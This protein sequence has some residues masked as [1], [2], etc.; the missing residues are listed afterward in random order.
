MAL[1]SSANN[2]CP[3][4]HVHGRSPI[5]TSIVFFFVFCF[6]FFFSMYSTVF[7]DCL[8]E[9]RRPRFAQSDLGLRFPAYQIGAI[10]ARCVYYIVICIHFV[11]IT[12]S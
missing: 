4:Q 7:I 9:K 8:N 1:M 5:R 6:L 2:E 12:I 3:N 11:I 10:F